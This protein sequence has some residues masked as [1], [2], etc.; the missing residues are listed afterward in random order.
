MDQ[1][2]NAWPNNVRVL[3]LSSPC[4]DRQAAMQARLEQAGVPY[5]AIEGVFLKTQKAVKKVC[6]EVDVEMRTD[7]E[8][9][10][11]TG[12]RLAFIR[13]V[14]YI[15][16]NRIPHTLYLEDDVVPNPVGIAK[17]CAEPA[18]FLNRADYLF[19]QPTVSFGTQ[20]QLISLKGATALYEA[21]EQLMRSPVL[22]DIVVWQNDVSNLHVES[23]FALDLPWLFSH[24]SQFNL[25]SQS[26]RLQQ[27]QH[28]PAQTSEPPACEPHE[29]P[30]CEPSE[31]PAFEPSEPPATEVA[32][33][34]DAPCDTKATE[35]P[36]APM[37]PAAAAD[38]PKSPV[39]IVKSMGNQPTVDERG[40]PI[41]VLQHKRT[42]QI[43]AALYVPKEA[44]TLQIGGGVG[45]VACVIHKK[46][47]RKHVVV[48]PDT[49]YSQPLLDNMV[50]HCCSYIVSC[51]KVIDV[52]DLQRKCDAHFNCLVADTL[53]SFAPNY[54]YDFMSSN[55]S[56]LKQLETV[57]FRRSSARDGEGERI[58]SLMLQHG[59]ACVEPGFITVYKRLG[60]V[61]SAAVS[62]GEVGFGGKLGFK[63]ME[64][65]TEVDRDIQTNAALVIS[66][67]APSR[68]TI[69]VPTSSIATAYLNSTAREIRG[70]SVK[71]S[72][73]GEFVGELWRPRQVSPAVMLEPGEHALELST[74]TLAFAHTILVVKACP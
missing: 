34:E 59:L 67:H 1:S 60:V 74:N 49:C 12:F 2:L 66:A 24:E 21:R 50:S 71:F 11:D 46:T 43:M 39:A 65:V 15:V 16:D 73:D 58:D 28:T 42:E 64:G 62:W 35:T 5:D 48:E 4:S 23:C 52:A 14:K 40:L 55:P 13:L 22:P 32:M 17:F 72:A 38:T 61:K 44:A 19:L 54:L 7:S 3:V 20:C 36:A 63:T 10:G 18:A 68:V 57:V 37:A 33:P 47:G 70:R 53:D 31:P 27:N 9:L 56:L 30:A 6:K 51:N 29:P 25:E 69:D 8:A 26:L 41:D 45:V